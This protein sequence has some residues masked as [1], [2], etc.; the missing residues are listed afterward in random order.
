VVRVLM[1]TRRSLWQLPAGRQVT[2]PRSG[3]PCAECDV[4]CSAEGLWAEGGS[5]T[6]W[7]FCPSP[8]PYEC[9]VGVWLFLHSCL[10]EFL[11]LGPL[12]LDHWTPSLICRGDSGVAAVTDASPAHV[13]QQWWQ[14]Q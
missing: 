11:G 8:S 5:F 4:P 1:V 10:M 6:C 13:R 2:A 3:S 12:T 14:W 7:P 9:E